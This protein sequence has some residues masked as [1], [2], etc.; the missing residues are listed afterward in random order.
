MS[1]KNKR[2]EQQWVRILAQK[3]L[4][5]ITS[6][7]VMLDQ[8]SND[9]IA[10]ISA[11]RKI[12]SHDEGLLSCLLRV[13]NNLQSEDETILMEISNTDIELS[14]RSIK[15]I[16]LTSKILQRLL[17]SKN[18]VPNIYHHLTL[19]IVNAF[20]AGLLAKMVA[21]DQSDDKQEA[22]YLTAI[23]YNI[24][25]ILFWNTPSDA[26]NKLIKD[27]S[28]P[29]KKF[30]KKSQQLLGIKFSAI[31]IGIVNTWHLGDLLIKEWDQPD[32]RDIEM[33]IV[34][35]ANQLSWA[36]AC[37]PDNKIEFDNILKRIS[38]I[39][40]VETT[41]LKEEIKKTRELAIELFSSY[42]G[43]IFD[44]HIKKLPKSDDFSLV[45]KNSFIPT[46]SNDKAIL[47][48]IK[49]LTKLCQNSH[50]ID[51]FLIFTLQQS[52]IIL[53]LNRCTFWTITENNSQIE[54]HKSYNEH[55]KIEKFDSVITL[56]DKTNL[57]S[58]VFEI[59]DA[60]FVNNDTDAKWG[61][62]MTPEIVKIIDKGVF[63][64]VP[65]KI[66]EKVVGL[67]SGQVFKKIEKF[68][69]DDFSQFCFLIGHLNMCLSIISHR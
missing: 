56:K 10:S 41:V 18:L 54:A 13:S 32:S 19:L 36:I 58:H 26:A 42:G 37:P 45:T 40:K 68:S 38:V 48:T 67:I 46:V 4:Q 57:V 16:C 65:V 61:D 24:G 28:L 7:A 47:A 30:Q 64:F 2:T 52:A 25:E 62:Y 53:G 22:I 11:L 29:A 17:A 60:I 33:Q 34:S 50:N 27:I 20:Y 69:N 3:E 59:D 5:E 51:D 44:H 9:D 39:M 12:I 15:N 6:I 23:L 35:L 66:D 63:C 1:E 55:G 31:S 21:T 43:S 14:I 49:Q 8:Y